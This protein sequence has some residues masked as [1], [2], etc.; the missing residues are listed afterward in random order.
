MKRIPP[1]YS[2][3]FQKFK[4]T[5]ERKKINFGSAKDEYN[6]KYNEDELSEAIQKA[7]DTA[8]GPDDIHYKI[9]KNLPPET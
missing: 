1:H 4:S 7:K 5:V 6:K 8:T 2:T 3:N 9:L